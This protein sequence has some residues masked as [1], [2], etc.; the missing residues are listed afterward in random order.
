LQILHRGAQAVACGAATLSQQEKNKP[1]EVQ[2][3]IKNITGFI[4][5]VA[6]SL[7]RR[8]T[9]DELKSLAVAPRGRWRMFPQLL[10]RLRLRNKTSAWA[11]GG[12]TGG[13][14]VAGEEQFGRCE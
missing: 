6:M 5:A 1:A 10:R 9:C 8:C 12:P 7:S 11:S 2:R 14:R 4:C 13:R 3:S